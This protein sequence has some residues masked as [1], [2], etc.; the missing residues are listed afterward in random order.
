MISPEAQ[1]F[2]LADASLSFLGDGLSFVP[3]DSSG[4]SARGIEGLDD[5][6]LDLELF[7]ELVCATQAPPPRAPPPAGVALVAARLSLY[8]HAD[9]EVPGAARWTARVPRWRLLLA[10]IM[11]ASGVGARVGL[12]DCWLASD[13]GA[14]FELSHATVP[15]LRR[16]ATAAGAVVQLLGL[17]GVAPRSLTC[18]GG[19]PHCCNPSH[20]ADG[21]AGG[22]PQFDVFTDDAA[23]TA[24]VPSVAVLGVAVGEM[25]GRG[26]F[27]SAAVEVAAEAAAWDARVPRWRA[28]LAE[29]IATL[30]A[31]TSAD[32]CW[33]S[34]VRARARACAPLGGLCVKDIARAAAAAGC[35]D[36]AVRA[37]VPARAARARDGPRRDRE[38]PRARR[39]HAQRRLPPR[40]ARVSEPRPLLGGHR[41]AQRGGHRQRPR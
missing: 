30:P 17:R 9:A 8:S 33:T 38:A 4:D 27:G 40:D 7:V 5:A 13:R 10:E 3:V 36:A 24:A 21:E 11:S 35:D 37:H 23:F 39:S 2:D 20:Y 12:R 15:P 22:A 6:P 32:D 28:V 18:P 25:R 41:R 31:G 26:D 29:F 16:R 1:R 19:T 14:L 34:R